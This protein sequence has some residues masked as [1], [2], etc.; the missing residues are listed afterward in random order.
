MSNSNP[1]QFSRTAGGKTLLFLGSVI[2]GFLFALSLLGID[3]IAK[4]WGSLV[5]YHSSEDWKLAQ[6][7]LLDGLEKMMP[8]RGRENLSAV[9]RP[10]FSVVYQLRYWIYVISAASFL[11]AVACI[12]FLLRAVG[13]R[14][15]TEEIFPGPLHKFPSDLLLLL[16][17]LCCAVLSFYVNLEIS[18]LGPSALD[19]NE[20]RMLKLFF[21]FS[22]GIVPVL[23]GGA[24]F[25]AELTVGLV[26]C[27]SVAGK[28][29]NR[30]LWKNTFAERFGKWAAKRLNKVAD[31]RVERFL[32]MKTVLLLFVGATLLE[33]V[34]IL[35]FGQWI[36]PFLLLWGIGKIIE[37]V[38]IL[39]F[40]PM[41]RQLRESASALADGDFSQLT[42][43]ERLFGGFKKHGQDLN[44]I[45]AG[46]NTAV[47][48]RLKSERTKAELITN[49]SHD[50]KTPLTSIINYA[51][52]I[53]AEPDGTV[54]REYS[55]VLVRQSVKLKRLLEDLIEVSKATTGNLDVSLAP[56]DAGIFLTQAAGEYQ[57]KLE[58]A[59][60]V[61]VIRQ[62]EKGPTIMAD[63]RRMWRIFDNLMNN[64]CQYSLPGSRVFLSLEEREGNAV[65]SFRNTSRE[66]LELS[67]EELTERFT[68]GDSARST[69]GHGLGLAI[70]VSLAEL[71]GGRLELAFEGDLFK[72]ELIFPTVEE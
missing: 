70:A 56:C 62:P 66:P 16:T 31:Y 1:K 25:L 20:D 8:W 9:V 47:E 10:A 50:I 24:L 72:A 6:E 63:G 3:I 49:V 59:G 37:L 52:L 58:A 18:P 68:R 19:P 35:W 27:M 40:A 26:F 34:V 7:M 44:R 55:E 69:E 28:V 43:T 64:I 22:E 4:D 53:A 36:I 21:L 14:P 38:A 32:G 61:P 5:Y 54:V 30:N 48:E 29:K 2:F 15:G 65:F 57:E 42:D 51:L 45:A 39:V 41:L 33:F 13:R 23:C 12:V 46:V 71:Q 11:L 17:V 67:P 60:L